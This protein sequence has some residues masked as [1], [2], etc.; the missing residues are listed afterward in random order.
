MQ[1][2]AQRYRSYRAYDNTFQPY[3]GPR[4]PCRSPYF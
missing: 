2:C 4:R 3:N 1:W